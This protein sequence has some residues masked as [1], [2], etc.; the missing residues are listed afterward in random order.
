[1]NIG[2]EDDAIVVE[3]IEEPISTPVEVPAEPAPAE[4]VKTQG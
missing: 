2:R 3:P 1:V 4:P